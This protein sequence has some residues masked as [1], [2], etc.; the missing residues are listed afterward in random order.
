MD[1][2]TQ[3]PLDP[4]AVHGAHLDRCVQLAREALEAGDDPFGSVLVSG[5]GSVQA[6]ARNKERSLADPTAHQEAAD[7]RT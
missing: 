2:M 1:P 4:V 6:E 7:R 5:E 3:P